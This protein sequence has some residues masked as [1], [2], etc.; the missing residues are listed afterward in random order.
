M[1]NIGKK[2]SREKNDKKDQKKNRQC[3]LNFAPEKKE[4]RKSSYFEPHKG[5]FNNYA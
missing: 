5:F 2:L 3:E 4:S 1:S